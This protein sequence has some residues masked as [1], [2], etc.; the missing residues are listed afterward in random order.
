MPNSSVPSI[1]EN[2]IHLNNEDDLSYF[3]IMNLIQLEKMIEL[4]G[5]DDDEIWGS[6]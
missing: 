4:W 5:N 3:K 6:I 1:D 2:Y